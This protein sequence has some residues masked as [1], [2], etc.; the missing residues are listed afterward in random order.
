MNRRNGSIG[1]KDCFKMNTALILGINPNSTYI[2]LE[3][4]SNG[5]VKST[6]WNYGAG[7]TFEEMNHLLEFSQNISQGTTRCMN[8]NKNHNTEACDFPFFTIVCSNCLVI[9]HDGSQHDLPCMLINKI[10]S[11]RKDLLA[12]N[13][14]TLFQIIYKGDRLIISNNLQ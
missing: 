11:I 2:K 6:E 4:Q 9:S 12:F 5:Q 1:L 10:S 7:W 14:V 8:C 3:V 13:A